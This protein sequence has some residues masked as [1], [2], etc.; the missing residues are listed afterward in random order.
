VFLDDSQDHIDSFKDHPRVT[1][2]LATTDME[3]KTF[4]Q[5]AIA[6]LKIAANKKL[7][8]GPTLLAEKTTEVT[9]EVT[10]EVTPEANKRKRKGSESN[11]SVVS[12]AEEQPKK[13]SN[14]VATNLQ[15]FFKQEIEVSIQNQV[16]SSH[17]TE[18]LPSH[19]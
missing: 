9:P 1:A 3:D 16:V 14:V 4:Y 7:Y 12:L 8:D 2:I 17:T 15:A 13:K 11:S 6:E 10:A 18:T 19:P 5:K